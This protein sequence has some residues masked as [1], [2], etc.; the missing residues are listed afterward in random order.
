MLWEKD[1]EGLV[2]SS[3]SPSLRPGEQKSE[4]K[5]P[6]RQF[7]VSRRMNQS[8]GRHL[9]SPASDADISRPPPVFSEESGMEGAGELEFGP[10]PEWQ[11]LQELDLHVAEPYVVRIHH[12]QQP[13]KSDDLGQDIGSN[14]EINVGNEKLK[15][16]DDNSQESEESNL[17]SNLRNSAAL[18]LLLGRSLHHHVSQLK[19]SQSS[20]EASWTILENWKTGIEAKLRRPILWWPLSAPKQECRDG[21]TRVAWNCVNL[22]S[23]P[24]LCCVDFKNRVVV[25]R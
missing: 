6:A 19:F 14:S 8:S 11:L 9:S 15:E 16:A 1:G 12:M 18:T 20:H 24:N 4:H 25:L 13:H 7:S 23:P 2:T 21:E 3:T 5:N 22:P 10:V 17:W